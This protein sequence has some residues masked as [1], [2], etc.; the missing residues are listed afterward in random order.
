[1]VVEIH[2]QKRHVVGDVKVAEAVV[3]LDAVV[4]VQ[5]VIRQMHV[6]EVE[7]AVAVSDP[8][9]R[10]ALFKQRAPPLVTN[11]REGLDRLESSP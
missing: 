4:N 8:T 5:R 6:V 1:M 9:L 2:R 10:H 7:I 11:L 3:E